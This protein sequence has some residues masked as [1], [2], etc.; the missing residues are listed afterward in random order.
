MKIDANIFWE[1]NLCLSV[2]NFF[3]I[4]GSRSDGEL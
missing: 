1:K 3:V 2:V 4:T